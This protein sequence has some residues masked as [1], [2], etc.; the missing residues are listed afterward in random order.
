MVNRRADVS[1]ALKGE[2][3]FVC[4]GDPTPAEK[5]QMAIGYLILVRTPREAIEKPYDPLENTLLTKAFS[6]PPSPLTEFSGSAH[7]CE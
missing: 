1:H 5:S 3:K 2:S 7:D 4:G 6:G